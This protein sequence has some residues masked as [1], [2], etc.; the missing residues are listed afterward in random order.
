MRYPLDVY[1]Q[2]TKP[3]QIL[4]VHDRTTSQVRQTVPSVLSALCVLDRMERCDYRLITMSLFFPA[5]MPQP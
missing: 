1:T 2:T 5:I 4:Y 3:N